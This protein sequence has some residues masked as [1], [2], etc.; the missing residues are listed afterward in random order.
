M[1]LPG[2]VRWRKA[3]VQ[4]PLRALNE[5]TLRGRRLRVW[6]GPPNRVGAEYFLLAPREDT[7]PFL[8]GL[9][10]VGP[11]PQHHWVEVMASTF[12]PEDEEGLFALFTRL[13]R[14][15]GHLMV[16]YESEAR[17]ET[18]LALQRGVPP[19]L[20]P[21]GLA[22]FRA[23]F[24]AGFRDWYIS[25]GGM[26]GPR[27]LQAHLPLNEEHGREGARRMLAEVEEFLRRGGVAPLSQ[28]E[29]REVLSALRALAR[30]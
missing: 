10:H 7:R 29:V 23:G 16:E 3:P 17:R 27:K 25:E 9:F 18:D 8:L 12:T 6:L 5:A 20:T 24:T 22:L 14:P 19:V 28:G 30:R 1:G 2:G 15:G 26:E 13:I 11:F 4:H 21:L